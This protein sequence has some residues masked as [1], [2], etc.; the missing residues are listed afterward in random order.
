MC[1]QSGTILGLEK[2]KKSSLTY[3]SK[4]AEAFKDDTADFCDFAMKDF[5]LQPMMAVSS[6]SCLENAENYVPH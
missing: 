6:C 3:L 5:P 2:K 4:H 1:N